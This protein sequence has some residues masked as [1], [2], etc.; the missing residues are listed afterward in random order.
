MA[1]IVPN[2]IPQVGRLS[3]NVYYVQGYSGHGIAT[4]HVLAEMAAEAI[5]GSQDRFD[6]FAALRHLRLPVGDTAGG[7]MLTLGAWYYRMREKLR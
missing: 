2:R 4:S 6:T 7:A 3:P 5:T 1:G